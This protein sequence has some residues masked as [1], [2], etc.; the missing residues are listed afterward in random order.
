MDAQ[1]WNARYRSAREDDAGGLWSTQPHAMLRQIVEKLPAGAA[2][3]LATGDGRNAIW[4]ARRGWR[5]T[6]VDYSVE[7]L[8][9]ART[10]E[11][12][13]SPFPGPDV[14]DAGTIDWRLGDATSW[15]PERSYDLIMITYLHLATAENITT[16][17]RA[18]GWLAPGGTLLVIGHDR[19]NLRRGVGGPQD[20]DLL[21]TPAM[22][23]AAAGDMHILAAERIT[24]DTTTDPERPQEE[25]RTAID[26]LLH[27]VNDGHSR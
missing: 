5:V 13:E 18:S 1:D 2:L 22:L 16:I 25:G 20:P 14:D 11:S 7:G 23:A 6:A 19:D 9:I 8:D 24:R 27:A 17:R 26:T 3:D 12:G 21:Y 15:E 10:R 4:M